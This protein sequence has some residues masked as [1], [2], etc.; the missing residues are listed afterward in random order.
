MTGGT[1]TAP[2]ICGRE[3]L[4]GK[5]GGRSG[6]RADVAAIVAAAINYFKKDRTNLSKVPPAVPF[7]AHIPALSLAHHPPTRSPTSWPPESTDPHTS[8]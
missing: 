5:L 1:T 4:E 6:R 3:C 8:H 7:G 2:F